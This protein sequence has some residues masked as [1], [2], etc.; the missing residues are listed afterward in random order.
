M[1][2]FFIVKF[3]IF[4]IRSIDSILTIDFIIYRSILIGGIK[5][6]QNF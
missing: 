4:I 2:F 3:L 6:L 1:D 5:W